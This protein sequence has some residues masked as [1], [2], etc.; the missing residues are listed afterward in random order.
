MILF[1]YKSPKGT[2]IVTEKLGVINNNNLTIIKKY[3]FCDCIIEINSDTIT[4]DYFGH[5][6][7]NLILP[8]KIM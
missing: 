2:H 3:G 1:K 5:Q 8:G 6:T 7:A 4:S